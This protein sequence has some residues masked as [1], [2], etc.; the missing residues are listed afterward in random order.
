M[1]SVTL[2]DSKSGLVKTTKVGYSWT[3]LFFGF[4]VPL[5]RGDWKWTLISLFLYGF[6]NII[7][8]FFYNDI[9]IKDLLADG[10]KPATDADKKV[11]KEAGIIG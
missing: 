1:I 9:Y 5:L 3:M 11:L 4:F 10:Y 8:S 7:F 2:K 6:A